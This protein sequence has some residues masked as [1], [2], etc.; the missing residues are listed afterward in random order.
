MKLVEEEAENFKPMGQLIASYTRPAPN[1]STKGKGKSTAAADPQAQDVIEYEV[2]HV[3]YINRCFIVPLAEQHDYRRPGI[4]QVSVNTTGGCSCSSCSISKEGPTL[5][6][7]RIPGSLL[8]C[9]FE[10]M[11]SAVLPN[12]Q[13]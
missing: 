4:R 12:P 6:R 9:K 10:G 13:A 11:Y 5:M 8:F 2:Y 3:R 1:A 7:T